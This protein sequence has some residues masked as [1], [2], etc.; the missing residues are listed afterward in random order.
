M[1]KARSISRLCYGTKTIDGAG[2]QLRRYFGREE[3]PAFD[4]FLQFDDISSCNPREFSRGYPWHPHRGIESVT[5]VIDG[6]VAHDD[7]LG[8]VNTVS[9]GE[10]RW[11]SAGSGVIHQ[12]MPLAGPSNRLRAFELW[13]NMPAKNK[14]DDP[15]CRN[16]TAEEIPHAHCCAKSLFRIIAGELDSVRGPV[17]NPLMEPVWFDIFLPPYSEFVYPTPLHHTFFAYLFEGECSFGTIDEEQAAK[18]GSSIKTD[19][20]PPG[21][22]G[23]PAITAHTLVHFSE[24]SFISTATGERPARFL[25]IGAKPIHEPVAWYGPIVMNSEAELKKAF[26]EFQVGTFVKHE[27]E[28]FCEN[29]E[30][31]P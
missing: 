20:P 2:V 13:I 14:M 7:T 28:V 9:A 8:N 6:A 12:E 3:L 27:R 31:Q 22:N 29:K 25:L 11:I 1:N 26:E 24:G 23:L 15:L 18:T 16:I 19:P 30:A 10:V 5:Y 17:N 4:P 21:E